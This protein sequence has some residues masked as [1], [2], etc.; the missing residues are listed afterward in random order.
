MK[1]QHSRTRHSPIVLTRRHIPLQQRDMILVKAAAAA[2]PLY[3]A[4][5]S[6]QYDI[7]GDRED[8]Y[9]ERQCPPMTS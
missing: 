4:M 1:T 5:A 3:E 6:V 9:G 2:K 8:V 7:A